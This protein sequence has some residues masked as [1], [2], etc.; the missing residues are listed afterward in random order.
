MA[1]NEGFPVGGEQEKWLHSA[2]ATTWITDLHPLND[3]VIQ[4]TTL[5]A[6][7]YPVELQP[8][9]LVSRTVNSF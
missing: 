4:F 2:E 9:E 8:I 5:Q 1:D 6:L 7:G 3:I